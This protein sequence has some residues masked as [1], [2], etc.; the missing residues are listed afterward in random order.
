MPRQFRLRSLF[1][2]TAVVAVGCWV[3]PR[4]ARNYAPK[5]GTPSFRQ[6][7][8]NY[9][10]ESWWTGRREIRRWHVIRTLPAD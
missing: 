1:V 6:I 5:L 3:G 4:L 8:R 7:D 2:L 10:E 9:G